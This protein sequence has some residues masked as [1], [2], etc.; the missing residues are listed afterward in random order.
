MWSEVVACNNCG[1]ELNV[2]DLSF[3]YESKTLYEKLKCPYCGAEQKRIEAENKV[4]QMTKLIRN[5][6][7]TNTKQEEKKE[8]TLNDNINLLF[9]VKGEKNG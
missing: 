9:G 7:V 4:I 5:L 3:D 2:H 8:N 6:P 1:K